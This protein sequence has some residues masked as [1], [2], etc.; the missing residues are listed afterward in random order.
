VNQL[1]FDQASKRQAVTSQG[2]WTNKD[3]KGEGH[4]RGAASPG[5]NQP[6][7]RPTNRNRIDVFDPTARS[8][9][10]DIESSQGSDH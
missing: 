9:F 8:H 5:P 2:V 4:R 3:P 6:P 1:V 10:S 7:G